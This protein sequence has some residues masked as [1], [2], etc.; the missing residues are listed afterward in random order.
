MDQRDL[1]DNLDMI[2][3]EDITDD[4]SIVDLNGQDTVGEQLE[5]AGGGAGIVP[6]AGRATTATVSPSL[7]RCSP[8]LMQSTSPQKRHAT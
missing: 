3:T 2:V 4:A 7:P 8:P 1:D 6:P 5:G